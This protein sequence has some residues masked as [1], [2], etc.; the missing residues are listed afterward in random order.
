MMDGKMMYMWLDA[1]EFRQ[2][3]VDVVEGS[4]DFFSDLF[5]NAQRKTR[6]RDTW[7]WM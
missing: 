3:G 5:F 4:V 1:L 2:D 6:E 7:M